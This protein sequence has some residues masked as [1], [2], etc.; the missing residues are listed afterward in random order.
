[1]LHGKSV[2]TSCCMLLHVV[3]CW[4]LLRKVWNQFLVKPTTSPNISV[5]P[6]SQKRSTTW[7]IH[8]HSSSNIVGA[9]HA[10]SIWSPNSYGL[11]SSHNALHR[12]DCWELLHPFVHHCQQGRKNSQDCWPNNVGS[13]CVRLHVALKLRQNGERNRTTCCATLLSF[14]TH[15]SN[16]LCSKTD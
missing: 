1:M 2:C 15:E 3:F 12:Q 7:W 11:Y 8:L 13:C 6:R 10:H 14:T 5:V 16:L 9:T 4:E